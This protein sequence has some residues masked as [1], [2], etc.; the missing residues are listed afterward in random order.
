MRVGVGGPRVGFGGPQ[1]ERHPRV[2]VPARVLD[3]SAA[4][5]RLHV[6]FGGPRVGFGGPQGGGCPLPS[7]H[8][9]HGWDQ[10]YPR[11]CRSLMLCWAVLNGAGYMRPPTS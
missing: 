10:Q 11:L 7:L 1:G 9:R 4:G 3:G 8:Y 2:L 6:G 5:V